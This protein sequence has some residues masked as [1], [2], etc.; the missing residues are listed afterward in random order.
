MAKSGILGFT[1]ALAREGA[2]Y[3]ILS[4]V[5]AP[6][7][8]SR[9]T[10]TVMP[11]DL[12]EMLKIDYIVP[13]VV[14]LSHE[15]CK[16]NGS[17]FELGGRWVS[18]IRYQRSEGEFFANEFTSESVEKSWGK[19]TCFEKNSTFPEDST[20][21]LQNMT[22]AAQKSIKGNKTN[23]TT[24]KSEGI[25]NL[26]KAYLTLEESKELNKKVGAVFQ[27][28]I[29]DKKGGKVIKTFVIDLLTGKGL[30]EGPA[31]KYDALFTM[32]DEDF[33]GVTNGQLNPQM[34]FI[35]V[36]LFF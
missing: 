6:V 36:I 27:F 29:L 28:E 20:S 32:T 17:T 12:L 15:N 7:A 16:E 14:Y 4:N 11:K 24:L 23:G 5:I 30:Y 9:M 10:E 13:L 3:N 2:K 22:E 25:I 19:I 31:E 21:G 8:A 1:K 33:F 26:I 18:K 35:Q 34:A